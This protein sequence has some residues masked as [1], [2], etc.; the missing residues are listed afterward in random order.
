MVWIADGSIRLDPGLGFLTLSLVLAGAPAYAQD[1]SGTEPAAIPAPPDGAELPAVEPIIPDIEFEQAIPDVDAASDPELD[2]PL[3]TIEEF[4]KRTS[5]D[6]ARIEPS[7][8]EPALADGD[9]LEEIG[10]A[11]VSDTELEKPLPPIEQFE[12]APVQFSEDKDASEAPEIVYKLEIDGLDAA[13]RESGKGLRGMFNRLSALRKGDGKAANVA[14]LSARLAEDGDLIK[15]ILASQGWYSPL[16]HTGIEQ[17]GEQGGQG[18][19]AV[20]EVDPGKRYTFSEI[21]VDAQPI[22]PPGLIRD[23]LALTPGEPIVAQRVQEAEARVAIALPQQG[24]PFVQVGQRDILLDRDSGDGT[25]T[26]PVETGP[27]SSFGS[28]A[29]E[30]DL[31]FDADHIAVLARFKRG[32][33]YDSR[34]VDDLRKALVATGLFAS[35]SVEPKQTGEAADENSE[36]ATVLVKQDAGPPRTVAGSV[37]YATGEGFRVEASWTHRNLFP[38]EGALIVNGLAGTKE[39]GTGVTFRRSNAGRRDRTFE[40]AAEALHSDFDAYSA[41]T[42]RLAAQMRYSSTPIWQ[43]DLTYSFGVEFLATAEK[44][45]DFDLGRRD[46]DTYYIA[47]I[48][49]QAGLDFT[50]D[51]LDP[52]EGFRLTA[53]ARPEGSIDGGFNLYVKTQLDASAYFAPGKGLVLAGR[54]R[55]GSIQGADRERIA[56][57]RRFYAGGGGS[58]RGF[59]YQKLGPQD[60]NGDPIGG[61]SL[62]EASAEVRYRFGDYGIVGFVDAGQSYA[63]TM[64][65]FSDLRFGA[66]IGARY[67]TNFGPLRL[68]VATP[69]DR[70]PGESRINVYVSIGQSF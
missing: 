16:V 11:P 14:M 36:Y 50:D 53:S 23:K 27:R 19:R 55:L 31:A 70:R 64:P 61:R 35:V 39:Q 65:R 68:D 18:Y 63:D 17:P 51:L 25:Y 43:K 33:L 29:T 47:G 49:G 9:R 3:E 38:P 40:I 44:D 58:V 62:N 1:S 56:P 32:E 60:P 13:A 37:G 46:R 66:G 69:L 52:T 28:F 59:A 48:N 42:G 34:Q 41:Y 6:D 57:S 5:R 4:E 45:F 12:L 15:T 20:I 8:H 26:L 22:E 7:L 21:V 2:R 24:Y 10:D 67:Y 30:G 54:F